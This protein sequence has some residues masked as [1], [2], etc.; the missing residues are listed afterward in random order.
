[1][2]KIDWR[3]QT[4]NTGSSSNSQQSGASGANR[5]EWLVL[6]FYLQSQNKLKSYES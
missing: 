5:N 2:R 3:N 1:M 6:T 4:S